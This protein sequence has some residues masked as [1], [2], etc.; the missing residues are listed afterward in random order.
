MLKRTSLLLCGVVGSLCFSNVSFAESIEGLW[1]TENE[2]AAIRLYVCKTDQ[3]CG[4]IAWI[5][6]GGMQYDE[7]NEDPSK[8]SNPLCGMQIMHSFVKDPD[9]E[10]RW[11]DGKIYKADDGDFYDAYMV[12][13]PENKLKLRGYAGITLF[14]KTQMWTRVSED[15]YPPCT[16][17]ANE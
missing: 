11:E 12:E 13:K 7:H 9:Q 17:P 1:L 3:I 8:R 5:I 10:K 4:D 16:V 6:K 15:D 2:R 14:G